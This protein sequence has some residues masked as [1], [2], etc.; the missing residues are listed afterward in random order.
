MS[1]GQSIGRILIFYGSTSKIL[2][3]KHLTILRFRLIGKSQRYVQMDL[4]FWFKNKRA[5]RW[6]IYWTVGGSM[7]LNSVRLGFRI[8]VEITAIEAIT[9]FTACEFVFGSGEELRRR[10][11][12]QFVLL[13]GLME[14]RMI[15][16]RARSCLRMMGTGCDCGIVE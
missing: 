9:G 14:L 4:S 1:L 5:T 11:M 8:W 7:L 6:E 10:L 16:G 3:F 2:P 15:S 12:E 13:I